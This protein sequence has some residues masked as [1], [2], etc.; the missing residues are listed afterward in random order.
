MTNAPIKPACPTDVPARRLAVPR[1]GCGGLAMLEL[2]VI[3]LIV[4]VLGFVVVPQWSSAAQADAHART[5]DVQ[6]Y[7]QTQI[8]VYATQHATPIGRVGYAPDAA[9]DADLMIAQLTRYTDDAGRVADRRSPAHPFGV[10]LDAWPSN[11]AT[12][13]R[14]L[15]IHSDAPDKSQASLGHGLD[16]GWHYAPVTGQI[17][18]CN[19]D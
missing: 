4:G 11:P 9:F 5:Q 19:V 13:G 15:R 10:Y 2:L 8:D 12:G 18:A 17:T 7:L 6:R 1:Q 16:C 3:V 14:G